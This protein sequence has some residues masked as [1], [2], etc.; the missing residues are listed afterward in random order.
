MGL[1]FGKKIVTEDINQSREQF[2]KFANLLGLNPNEFQN[3][4]QHLVDAGSLSAEEAHDLVEARPLLVER[5][6][7]EKASAEPAGS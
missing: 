6:P 3:E 7:D 1:R 2:V 4:L 5:F